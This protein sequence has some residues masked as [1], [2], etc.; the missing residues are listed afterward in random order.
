MIYLFLYETP[1]SIAYLNNNSDIVRLLSDYG[2][3][4]EEQLEQLKLQDQQQQQFQNLIEKIKHYILQIYLHQTKNAR[5]IM[6]PLTKSNELKSNDYL[7][8]RVRESILHHIR[9]GNLIKT[10]KITVKINFPNDIQ[11]SVFY[12]V[13]K[14]QNDK[15]LYYN[16]MYFLKRQFPNDDLNYLKKDISGKIKPGFLDDFLDPR[17][18]LSNYIHIFAKNTIRILKNTVKNKGLVM[19]PENLDLSK[20]LIWKSVILGILLLTTERFRSDLTTILTYVEFNKLKKI[21]DKY[22]SM[23]RLE[24]LFD[25]ENAL[26]IFPCD[27][28]AYKIRN[29]EISV[30]K[31]HI[32]SL[33]DVN[34]PIQAKYELLN[35]KFEKMKA[36]LENRPISSSYKHHK[37]EK[38]ILNQIFINIEIIKWWD[39]NDK[40]PTEYDIRQNMKLRDKRTLLLQW[41]EN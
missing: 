5:Y 40:I 31:K 10:F 32:M 30:I 33:A 36:I 18:E 2:H 11:N 23:M 34:L 16:T 39:E 14:K 29:T 27:R 24:Q 26:L 4:S 37:I 12:L 6:R 21:N 8:C 38:D 35:K 15:Y 28:G 19:I 41:D 1:I 22:Q 20:E 9:S 7:I 25:R 3:V 17:N 13:N